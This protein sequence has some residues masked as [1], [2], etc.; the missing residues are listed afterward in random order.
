MILQARWL[1]FTQQKL[2]VPDIQLQ[3]IEQVRPIKMCVNTEAG[4]NVGSENAATSV[5]V[6]S[7]GRPEP[8]VSVKFRQSYHRDLVLRQWRTLKGS[9]FSVMEDMT[10]L[11]I[12]TESCT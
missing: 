2:K 11:N 8:S 5:N 9:K 1:E 10:A 6:E 4:A 3:D 12:D 7:K